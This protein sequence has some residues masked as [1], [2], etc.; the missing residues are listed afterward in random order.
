M[1]IPDKTDFQP[2]AE[3]LKSWLATRK[4]TISVGGFTVPGFFIDNGNSG[5]TTW[6]IIAVFGE[7]L[8][9]AA[10]IYGGMKSGGLFMVLAILAVVLFIV[11]DV[12]F[13]KWLHRNEADKCIL[14]S[15]KLLKDDNAKK[16]IAD[17]NNKLD[18]GKFADFMFQTGIILI[19]VLK[20][21]GIVILGLFN[22]ISLYLPFAIIFIIV[23]YVHIK[24]TGYWLAYRTTEK[25]ISKEYKQFANGQFEARNAEQPVAT[26]SELRNIPIKYNPHEII[27]DPDPKQSKDGEYYYV[28]KTKGVLT[29]NDIVNLI[30]GQT[31]GNKM[32]LFKKCRQLQLESIESMANQ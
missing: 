11:L 13:A 26:N 15:K 29:D 2:S 14:E 31:D 22:H 19:A 20:V 6:I 32:L 23:A 17:L 30:T 4:P 5:D 21:F 10:T 18:K 8:G 1:H 7:L 16:D 3:T 28:V 24:H 27:Y 25:K 9:L 12:V